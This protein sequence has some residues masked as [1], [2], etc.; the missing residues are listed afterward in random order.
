MK[1]FRTLKVWE[2]SHALVLAIYKATSLFPKQEL[3]ALTGQIQRAAVSIPTNMAEGCGKDSDR[4]L[5]RY[6]KIAMGSSSELE[7]LLLLAHDLNYLP[8]DNYQSLYHDLVEV[9]KMLN[10]FI[11]RLRVDSQGQSP[12]ADS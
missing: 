12:K 1:D 3:Y 6:F 11:Q 5:G 10:A 7:Y 4:E 8:D 2:K 9:R